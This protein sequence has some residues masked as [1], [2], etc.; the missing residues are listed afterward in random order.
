MIMALFIDR[1]ADPSALAAVV[2][3]IIAFAIF[4]AT[5][6]VV[7]LGVD[8]ISTPA[9]LTN[10]PSQI[11]ALCGVV[12]VMFV[13]VRVFGVSPAAYGL[14]I[15]SRWVKNIFG[16]IGIG[17]LFQA[18]STAAILVTE[19]GTIVDRWSMGV[20]DGP[21]TVLIA[22]GL[23]VVAFFIIA[24][25]E[26][27]L[28]RGVLIRELVVG[29]VSHDTSRRVATGVA[30]VV[31]ALLFGVIHLGAEATGLSAGVVLLQAVVGGLYFGLAYA[32]TDSLGLPV[33]IHFSTN[34]WT[35]VVFGQPNSGFPA[36][37]R[38]TR[39]FELS[40][41]LIVTFVFPVGVLVVAILMWARAI[42]DGSLE[43]A[44]RVIR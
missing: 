27:F 33:G 5:V 36:A 39:P 32:L 2:R 44:L 21:V 38:L 15:T 24:L 4:F 22:I 31:S 29:L 42:Q 13:S 12:A 43:L 40:S 20:A 23:T 10:L 30:V 28:F 11:V 26:Y 16:G 3:T 17:F 37:F 9:M 1:G 35:I 14:K 19:S 34:L 25:A 18:I 7:E 41:E 6:A 8:Q